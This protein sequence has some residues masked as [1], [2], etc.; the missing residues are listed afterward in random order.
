MPSPWAPISDTNI[1]KSLGLRHEKSEQRGHLIKHAENRGITLAQI[2]DIR[3]LLQRLCKAH[4]LRSA[5]T[6]RTLNWFE[7]SRKKHVLS[8][9]CMRSPCI[10]RSICLTFETA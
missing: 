6:G 8:A 10:G 2:R 7:V 4:L 5:Y 9:D 3:L 1:L